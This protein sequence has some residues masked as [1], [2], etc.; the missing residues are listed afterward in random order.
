MATQMGRHGHG[1]G[2]AGGGVPTAYQQGASDVVTAAGAVYRSPRT[3]RPQLGVGA[4]GRQQPAAKN[5]M[6]MAAAAGQ[7]SSLGSSQ[8][9][10]GGPPTHYYQDPTGLYSFAF[11]LSTV[12]PRGHS[13]DLFFLVFLG[14]LAI[15]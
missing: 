13:L 14:C 4:V 9:A 2:V 11:S 12:A 5:R 8:P 15:L 10:P 6:I 1:G 7:R 3:L